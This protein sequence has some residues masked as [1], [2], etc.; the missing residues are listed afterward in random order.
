[1]A[2][3]GLSQYS[4]GASETAVTTIITNG[5]NT[6][7]TYLFQHSLP[8]NLE[9]QDNSLNVYNSSSPNNNPVSI[10]ID[11]KVNI[12]IDSPELYYSSEFTINV[13]Y[14]LEISG[15]TGT[16]NYI[17]VTKFQAGIQ[18]VIADAVI[19]I[20]PQTTVTNLGD[21]SYQAD[22]KTGDVITAQLPHNIFLWKN[23]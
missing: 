22:L 3:I 12:F 6:L 11:F 15:T 13:T 14:F 20:T 19:T 10:H 16:D 23:V 1:M 17:F 2:D 7:E 8:A 18:S 4:L 5:L 9:L 21:G